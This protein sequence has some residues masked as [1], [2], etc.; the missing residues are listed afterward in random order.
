MYERNYEQACVDAFKKESWDQA[1][2]AK[3]HISLTRPLQTKE[4]VYDALEK[5]KS[6]FSDVS[7]NVFAKMDPSLWKDEDLALKCIERHSSA[8][9]YIPKSIARDLDF[10]KRAI[11]AN[12][13]VFDL[14]PAVYQQNREIQGHYIDSMMAHLEWQGRDSQYE[15]HHFKYRLSEKVDLDNMFSDKRFKESYEKAVGKSWH[16]HNAERVYMM[17]AKVYAPEKADH[18]QQLKIQ[19]WKENPDLIKDAAANLARGG[20][21]ELKELYQLDPELHEMFNE[22]MKIASDEYA[23]EVIDARGRMRNGTA[24]VFDEIKV[25]KAQ[26]ERDGAMLMQYSGDFPGLDDAV[27]VLPTD[28]DGFEYEET[29][30]EEPDESYEIGER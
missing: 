7:K 15:L 18:F 25:E 26:D 13:T 19:V 10:V 5:N 17:A 2:E 29:M 24:S 14:L 11:E 20:Y 28:Q 3:K 4:E 23:Q 6:M 16:L 30:F 27:A 22:S 21:S 8:Y 12:P 9:L 1:S